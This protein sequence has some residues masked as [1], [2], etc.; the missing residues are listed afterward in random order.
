VQT[1]ALPIF[2]SDIL[3]SGTLQPE[4]VPRYQQVIRESAEDGLDY[5]R[6]Y[7]ETQ[8]NARGAAGREDARVALADVVERSVGRYGL[9]FED[10]GCALRGGELG[11]AVVAQIGR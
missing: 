3:A 4:R 9:E 6:R 8:A 1:C 10:S 7:L 11:P 5:I 2:A